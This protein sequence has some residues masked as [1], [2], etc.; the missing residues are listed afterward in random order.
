MKVFEIRMYC[1]LHQVPLRYF[2]PTD[3]GSVTE[4]FFVR[5]GTL[6]SFGIDFSEVECTSIAHNHDCKNE[7]NAWT[8]EVN[9][10]TDRRHGMNAQMLAETIRNMLDV[11]RDTARDVHGQPDTNNPE[12]QRRSRKLYPEEFI[13]ATMTDVTLISSDGTRGFVLTD[14]E[15]RRFQVKVGPIF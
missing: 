2:G 1:T 14:D 6:G 10:R 12:E 15:G 4:L 9:E 11:T 13:R 3:D 7:P 8:V 5:E